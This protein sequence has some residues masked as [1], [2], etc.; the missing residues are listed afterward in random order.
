MVYGLCAPDWEYIFP[1]SYSLKSLGTFLK[2]Q[3]VC[4]G[5]EEKGLLINLPI[6]HKIGSSFD[7]ILH[8]HTISDVTNI[9][10]L[11]V[12][13]GKTASFGRF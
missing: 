2:G 13:L 9:H 10:Q 8:N 5:I 3:G 12:H 1:W 4:G 6:A 11:L 7:L